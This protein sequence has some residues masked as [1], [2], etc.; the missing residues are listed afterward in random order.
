VCAK[1]ERS[2]HDVLCVVRDVV[3]ESKIVAGGGAP[4]EKVTGGRAPKRFKLTG[5]MVG[6]WDLN[7]RQAGDIETGLNISR[8]F[9]L[10]LSR[11]T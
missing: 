6:G 4:E 9:P 2:I 1:G 8:N 11:S 7:P 10:F 5:K 3:N